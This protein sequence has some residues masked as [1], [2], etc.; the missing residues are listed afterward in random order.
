MADPGGPADLADLNVWQ[1]ILAELRA[2]VDAESFRRWFASTGYASDSGD[3]ITVWVS[4]DA[5]RRHV[6]AHYH[7][8]LRQAVAAIG[9]GGTAVRFV[10]TGD[11]DEDQDPE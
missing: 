2:T 8:P 10:V 1:R 9:R 7:E 11:D 3:Q 5:V 4:S 6:E